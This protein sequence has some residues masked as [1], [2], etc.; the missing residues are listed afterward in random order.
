M[1]RG[2]RSLPFFLK[3]C[4]NPRIVACGAFAVK[5]EV[6]GDD[7]IAKKE[8]VLRDEGHGKARI[9]E[10]VRRKR[11]LIVLDDTW[12]ESAAELFVTLPEGAREHLLGSLSPVDAAGMMRCADAAIANSVIKTVLEACAYLPLAV[13]MVAAT[14]TETGGWEAVVAALGRAKGGAVERA[15]AVSLGACACADSAW[16]LELAIFP[17]DVWVPESTL[18][19]FFY[20]KGKRDDGAACEFEELHAWLA[21]LD[22]RRLLQRQSSPIPAV[23]L[24]DLQLAYLRQQAALAGHEWLASLHERLLQGYSASINAEEPGRSTGIEEWWLVPDDGYFFEWAARHLAEARGASGIAEAQELLSNFQWLDAKL[25][26]TRDAAGLL[27]ELGRTLVGGA[28]GPPD[29]AE[30]VRGMALSAHVLGEEPAQLPF[31][32]CGRLPPAAA[33]ATDALSAL[34]RG[35]ML[36]PFG[37]AGGAGRLGLVPRSGLLAPVS[38]PLQQTLAAHSDWVRCVARSEDGDWLISGGNDCTVKVWG[39]ADGTLRENLLGHTGTVRGVTFLGERRAAS[40]SED[41]QLILWELHASSRPGSAALILRWTVPPSSES[42]DAG[43]QAIT[44]VGSDT[45]AVTR[46]CEVLLVRFPSG[47]VEAKVVATLDAHA[48]PVSTVAGAPAAGVLATASQ[49]GE[50]KVWG[51]AQRCLLHVL[52]GCS[53]EEVRSVALSADARMVVAGGDDTVG[54]LWLIPVPPTKGVAAPGRAGT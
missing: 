5:G 15:L 36:M 23:R 31:Q 30:L 24:H 6:V 48:A 4:S 51:V 28:P 13:G 43:Y 25:R 2:T 54:R 35:T 11:A 20:G 38:G 19:T 32:L 49:A 33:A 12:T 40:V 3:F 7:G 10:L 17:E 8:N 44:A 39:L 45:L 34:E 26:A 1:L 47:T 16:Y 9:A 41:A 37:K 29:C 22:E 21:R 27:A 18:A 46:G 42:G 52:P 53:A 50:V 14:V